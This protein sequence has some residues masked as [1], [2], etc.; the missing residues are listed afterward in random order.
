MIV[1]RTELGLGQGT[2]SGF[3]TDV[4]VLLTPAYSTTPGLPVG[5][6][7]STGA[8]ASSTG[9]TQVPGSNPLVL[10][11]SAGANASAASGCSMSGGTWSDSSGCAM[12]TDFEP[13]LV[14]GALLL[15]AFM[16]FKR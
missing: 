13:Y 2:T 12:P 1:E 7:P 16:I 10:S 6:D 15:F 3:D 9:I 11:A 8:L 14:I 4:P 5:Y